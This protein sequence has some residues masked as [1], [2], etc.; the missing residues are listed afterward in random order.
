[1]RP[2]AESELV[3]PVQDGRLLSHLLFSGLIGETRSFVFTLAPGVMH[4]FVRVRVCAWSGG[5]R[6][7]TGRN[8]SSFICRLWWAWH[9]PALSHTHPVL[10]E[11]KPNEMHRRQCAAA[12]GA[13]CGWYRK[14]SMMLSRPLG[15]LKKTKRD[16]WISQV[17]CW[18]DWRGEL[19]VWG[20]YT[21]EREREKNCLRRWNPCVCG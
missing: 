14:S 15:W 5:L 9:T 18:S 8:I 16:Q 13:Y 3:F 1:M 10:L 20:I 12:E 11:P 17:L 4:V 21:H 2:S 6:H 19:T 7:W